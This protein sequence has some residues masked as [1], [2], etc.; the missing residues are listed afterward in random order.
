LEAR[1]TLP[2]SGG[3]RRRRGQAHEFEAPSE[4]KTNESLGETIDVIYDPA[5]P[6]TASVVVSATTIFIGTLIFG[7]VG[8]VFLLVGLGMTWGLLTRP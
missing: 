1:F 3:G 8:S 7:V 4:P 6:E 2:T 5:Q